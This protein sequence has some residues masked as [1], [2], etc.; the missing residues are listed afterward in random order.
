MYCERGLRLAVCSRRVRSDC[1]PARGA[2][3]I[4]RMYQSLP[5]SAIQHS[6]ARHMQGMR[7]NDGRFM[8]QCRNCPPHRCRR[9]PVRAALL[10]WLLF[11]ADES[12]PILRKVGPVPA[13]STA[14]KPE[15]AEYQARR[16]V[17]LRW[18]EIRPG[19]YNSQMYVSPYGGD[20]C[21]SEP[22]QHNGAIARQ[23]TIKSHSPIKSRQPIPGNTARQPAGSPIVL[24]HRRS[25]I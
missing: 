7:C 16:F 1:V 24:A 4:G 23:P 11:V 19:P 3:E 12:H 15:P 2:G 20:E 14:R 17:C 5:I 9:W 8:A 13:P 6:T 21:H 18:L 10:A 22:T 25:V